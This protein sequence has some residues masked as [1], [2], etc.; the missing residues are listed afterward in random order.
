MTDLTEEGKEAL[1]K[2]LRIYLKRLIEID[3]LTRSV[4]RF[5]RDLFDFSDFFR[6]YEPPLILSQEQFEALIKDLADQF[7]IIEI[8]NSAKRFFIDL[9]RFSSEN[10]KRLVIAFEVKNIKGIT[11]FTVEN[12]TAMT[13]ENH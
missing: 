7:D 6:C 5:L 3:L 4:Y 1:L 2:L 10:K 12:V 8:S 9:V 11:I 13:Y